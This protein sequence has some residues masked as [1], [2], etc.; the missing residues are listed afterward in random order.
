MDK[1]FEVYTLKKIDKHLNRIHPNDKKR[2][3]GY[4]VKLYDSPFPKGFDIIKLEGTINSF[5]ARIGKV[6]IIYTVNYKQKEIIII[7]V[8][9]RKNAYRN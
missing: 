1:K 4:F 7:K 3:L 5:R 6:R 2:I 8:K 9:Y